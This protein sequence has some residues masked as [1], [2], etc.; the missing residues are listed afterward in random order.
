[1]NQFLG[2][3]KNCKNPLYED[4]IMAEIVL[5]YTKEHYL[6]DELVK[7]GAENKEQT[8]YPAKDRDLL[9]SV[10]FNLWKQNVINMESDTE[11]VPYLEKLKKRLKKQPDIHTY[12]E[13][14]EISR[15]NPFI[16]NYSIVYPDKDWV[17]LSSKNINATREKDL[18]PQ[19]RLYINADARDLYK[20]VSIFIYRCYKKGLPYDLKFIKNAEDL[21]KR[22]DSIVLWSDEK[23]L[24]KHI[25]ILNEIQDKRSDI[26][27]RCG[28]PPILTMKINDWVGFGEEPPQSSYTDYR[29]EI[30]NHSIEEALFR[31]IIEN[32]NNTIKYGEAEIPIAEYILKNSIK[33]SFEN[34]KRNYENEPEEFAKKTG[35]TL[36]EL[37]REL[38]LKIYNEIKAEFSSTLNNREWRVK[39]N[40]EKGSLYLNLFGSFKNICAMLASSN[41]YKRDF[42]ELIRENVKQKSK[43]YGICQEKFCF[44]S[45]FLDRAIQLDELEK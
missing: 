45:D 10:L 27:S 14:C 3:Y 1:M 7:I 40:T 15:N 26:V 39:Y 31:W 11:K 9:Y 13:F 6:Y 33:R 30:L 21:S 18:N 25:N 42:F 37:N 29:S 43:E 41:E 19:F 8:E 44:N 17:Y 4:D 16:A 20:L 36:E 38:Y 23:N 2:L 22:A 34:Y 24:F 35:I 28:K 12:K 32:K 5:A